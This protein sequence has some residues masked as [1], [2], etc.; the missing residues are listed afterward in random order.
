MQ[1]IVLMMIV[2]CFCGMAERK[3]LNLILFL[4]GT[5]VKRSHYCK[6]P[7]SCEQDLN[8]RSTVGIAPTPRPHRHESGKRGVSS[9]I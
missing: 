5:I 3:A 9:E 4:A 7:T 8:L 2:H 1:L 6:L